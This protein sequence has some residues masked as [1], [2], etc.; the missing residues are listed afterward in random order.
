MSAGCIGYHVFFAG[1]HVAYLGRN[2]SQHIERFP[3]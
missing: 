2:G 3:D 1:R